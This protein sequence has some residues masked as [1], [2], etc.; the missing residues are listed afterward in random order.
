MKKGK[1]K[2]DNSS[3]RI[4]KYSELGFTDDFLFCKILQ[5]DPEFCKEVVETILD[6]KI[7]KII[8]LDK[9]QM[10]EKT[11]DGRGVRLDV[12]LE[13][14]SAVYDIEMQ[15]ENPRNLPKRSRYYQGM[16]DLNN[17]ERGEDFNN[18]K[19]TVIAFITTFD[20]FGRGLCR[21]TF[22]NTCVEVSGLELGDESLKVFINAKGK[23]T[24]D[25]SPKMR[26]FLNYVMSERVE[27]DFSRRL[28][29]RVEKARRNTEWEMEYMT[30]EWKLEERYRTAKIEDAKAMLAEGISIEVIKKITG[31]NPEDL[32]ESDESVSVS[33]TEAIY[34]E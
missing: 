34:N 30:L 12:Y 7:R 21:Y 27:G 20:P 11:P 19:K 16:I 3:R 4:K 13:G 23:E 1:E 18:L 6:V 15:N 8:Q 17:L 33:E 29:D 5:E 22:R 24:D 9:Q 25:I 10:I 28:E 31:I 14:D 2:N 32:K 26:D